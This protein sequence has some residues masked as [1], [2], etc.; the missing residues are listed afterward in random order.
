M[1]GVDAS[2][3][4]H[5][6]ILDIPP[7]NPYANDL[8]GRK[9][10]AESLRS[11]IK[12]TDDNVVLC[13]DAPWG[14]GKTSF[15]RMWMADLQKREI[16]CIYYDAYENDYCED[17]FISFS[18]E[19]ISFVENN[20]RGNKELKL[21]KEEFKTKAKRIGSKVLTEGVKIGVK[22]LTLGVIGNSDIEACKDIKDDL[23]KDASQ[24][25]SAIVGRIFD[26]YIS[27]KNQINEFK[28][29]LSNI[30]QAVKDAQ[31]FPLLIIIDELDRCRPDFALALLERIKH[32]YTTNYVSFILLVNMKQ[33]ENYVRTIYGIRI[34]ARNYLHKFITLSTRLPKNKSDEY[35]NDYAKYFRLLLKHHG[36]DDRIDSNRDIVIFFKYYNFSLREI[37]QCSTILTVYYSQLPQGYF[38]PSDIICF[39]VVLL[40][41][42]PDAFNSMA[43]NKISY[44]ELAN[45]TNFNNAEFPREKYNIIDLI[46]YLLLS[47]EEYKK[48]DEN[49]VLK[50]YDGWL[51]T[52][53]FSRQEVI[54]FLCSELL[55]F[56]MKNK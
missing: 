39:L 33:L 32:L 31:K 25:S 49:N 43:E 5:P 12:N 11:L 40:V 29:K 41:R 4:I 14:D 56:K 28:E 51:R 42:H 3:K 24:V 27:T 38:S 46:K 50:N 36:I 48:L 44:E 19:I 17:P 37:E 54:P 20:F 35:D 52:T 45:N 47:V 21:L 10:F 34:D 23:A 16:N 26:N 18:A 22:A 7:D 2:M 55:K 13:V 8:F 1:K 15:A 9:A 30:G 6:P 53:H